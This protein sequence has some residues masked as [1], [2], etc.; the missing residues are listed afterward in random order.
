MLRKLS[1]SIACFTETWLDASFSDNSFSIDSYQPPFRKDRVGKRGGGVTV[2][3]SSQLPVRRLPDLEFDETLCLEI[4]ISKRK[5]LLLITTYRPPI[6]SKAEVESYFSKLESA[7]SQARA[8]KKFDGTFV[9]GDMNAKHSDWLPGSTTDAAGS[10]AF[11]MCCTLGLVQLVN[12]K[13][14]LGNDHLPASLLDLILTD[15]Q[16]LIHNVNVL[17]PLG[18][19][20]HCLVM[21]TLLS[22]W[23][24]AK[25]RIPVTRRRYDKVNWELLNTELFGLDWPSILG[26]LSDVDKAVRGFTETLVST[27]ERH[28]P[29]VTTF[30]KPSNKPWYSPYLHRLRRIRDRLFSRLHKASGKDYGSSAAAYKSVRNYYVAELR[31][32]EKLYYRSLNN[33]MSSSSFTDNSRTW[34]KLARSVC[35]LNPTTSIPPIEAEGRFLNNAGAKAECFNEFF[36]RQCTIDDRNKSPPS[37]D[38]IHPPGH[39]QFKPVTRSEVFDQLRLLNV[40]KAPGIDLLDNTVLRATAG[41][42]SEPLTAIFNASLRSARFPSA[43][44]SAIVVPVY[45]GKGDRCAVSS[46]RPISLTVST[47]KIFERIVHKQILSYLL[48]NNL[49]SE[50]QFGFLPGRSTL[51]ELATILQHLHTTLADSSDRFVRAV[52][53]D[54][55]KAFDKIW[56]NGLLCKLSSMGFDP[57]WFKSYLNG[58][59]QCTRA[60]G[61]TSSFTPIRAG[62]PQGTVLG[63]LLFLCYVGDL[64]STVSEPTYMFADDTALIAPQSRHKLQDSTCKIQSALN[65]VSAWSRTWF[66]SFNANK[67]EDLIITGSRKSPI[68]PVPLTLHGEVIPQRYT[69][70]HLGIM[71]SANLKWKHHLL[72]L[73]KKVA[74]KIGLL[75][76]LQHRLPSYFIQTIYVRVIRPSLEYASPIWD[77]LSKTDTLLLENIQLRVAKLLAPSDSGLPAPC[78]L[79]SLNLPTLA[80]RRRFSRLQLFW[81]LLHGLGPPELIRDMPQLQKQRLALHQ[82]LRRPFSVTQPRC[83]TALHQTSWLPRSAAEWN[84]LSHACQSAPSLSKFKALLSAEAG[85]K[86][87]L[88]LV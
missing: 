20:D 6:Q 16:D 27:V 3:V 60:D 12:Q 38:Q 74:S 32:A 35:G 44:K 52:F 31:H 56:H 47:S 22:N 53:L 87:I 61:V 55:S 18:S 26:D 48:K 80:W 73:Q 19:S 2:Y 43:W 42:I 28:V 17:P 70:R 23:I 29:K 41:N 8:R 66:V 64:P 83:K 78:L 13:T 39:F 36:A 9:V 75:R 15:R 67:S 46:Y 85:D 11:D 45:K 1:L 51:L 40:A 5:K 72:H 84:Q 68:T 79:K 62:V 69:V 77:S 49:I 10:A 24:Q 30:I 25:K 88:G 34:W 54:I 58:R 59:S 21:T 65:E 81:K 33:Q 71:L 37:L 14:R 50:N 86:Y 63:P 4:C 82:T 76:R 7:I 57:A